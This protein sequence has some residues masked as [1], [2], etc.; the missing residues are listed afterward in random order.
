MAGDRSTLWALPLPSGA[1]R[2]VAGVAGRSPQ[3]FGANRVLFAT[4]DWNVMQL[5]TAALDGSQVLWGDYRTVEEMVTAPDALVATSGRFHDVHQP[6][7]GTFPVPGPGLKELQ[8][9]SSQEAE[10]EAA[11]AATRAGRRWTSS[12]PDS[13]SSARPRRRS[14]RARPPASGRSGLPAAS[15]ASQRLP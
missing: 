12:S 8:P 6:G 7:V 10:A 3:P 14:G 9:L 4:G 15:G 1:E 11:P 2:V 5:A 13:G